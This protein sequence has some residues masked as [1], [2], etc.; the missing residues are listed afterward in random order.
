MKRAMKLTF[1]PRKIPK[2]ICFRPSEPVK[3]MLARAS[4]D[5][6]HISGIVNECVRAHLSTHGYATKK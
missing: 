5:H 4:V 2:I 1:P 6:P 3:A